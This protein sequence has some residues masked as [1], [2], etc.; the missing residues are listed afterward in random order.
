MSTKA[1]C[2]NV[3]AAEELGATFFICEANQVVVTKGIDGFL[4]RETFEYVVGLQDDT[5]Y[6]SPRERFAMIESM[7][8]LYA[9]E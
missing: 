6:L 8:E 1:I 2:I 7:W 5:V 4:P 3:R 9:E